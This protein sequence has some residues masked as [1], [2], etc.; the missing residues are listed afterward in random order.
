MGFLFLQNL[1]KTSS[2]RN[3]I[4][5]IMS[6]LILQVLRRSV[7]VSG[8]DVCEREKQNLQHQLIIFS[9]TWSYW[10]DAHKYPKL[11][12]KTTRKTSPSYNFYYFERSGHIGSEIKAD[13]VVFSLNLGD[14]RFIFRDFEHRSC[15]Q[16][17]LMKLLS[18][19]NARKGIL[20]EV[21]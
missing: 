17:A 14:S 15:M 3:V 16:L 18:S 6:P 12:I 4:F 8:N 20:L 7:L 13:P 19:V 11:Q 1:R 10:I 9:S 21:V 2:E 5:P